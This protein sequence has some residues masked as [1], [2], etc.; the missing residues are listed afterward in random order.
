[1]YHV[2]LDLFGMNLEVKPYCIFSMSDLILSACESPAKTLFSN[3]NNAASTT[4]KFT[5]LMSAA[6]A[7]VLPLRTDPSCPVRTP[8]THVGIIPGASLSFVKLGGI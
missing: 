7:V 8:A 6:S 2:S 5:E 4:S 1:M 3:S